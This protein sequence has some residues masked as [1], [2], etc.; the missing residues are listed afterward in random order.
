MFLCLLDKGNKLFY[1]SGKIIPLKA[2]S[3]LGVVSLGSF[4]EVS[5]SRMSIRT[6]TLKRFSRLNMRFG[7]R[8]SN[9]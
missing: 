5:L 6:K 7:L 8:S 3:N 1:I 2:V 9:L 4:V